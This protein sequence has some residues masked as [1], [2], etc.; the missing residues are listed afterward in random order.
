MNR[1]VHLT[2]NNSRGLPIP[3][4]S[5]Q[6]VLQI[7]SIG[8]LQ[9]APDL[10]VFPHSFSDLKD[11]IG[12]LSIV[13]LHEAQ[14]ADGKCVS[15]KAC[16]GNLMGFVGVNESSVSIHSR[17]THKMENGEVDPSSPDYF[18]YYMLQKV[19]SV[20]VFSLEH[21]SSRDDKILDFLFFLFPLMLKSAMSQGLYKEYRRFLHD[22][23]RV[24][25]TIDV[26]RFI[27]SDIPFRGNI[28]Y[29]TREYSYDNTIT[30]LVR[31]TIEYITHH[32]FGNSIL[33]N[34][35]ET[36]E[37]VRQ[38]KEATP[39]YCMRDRQRVLNENRRPKVHPYFTKYRELQQLCVHILRHESLKY[40]EEKD[41][42]HGVLFDGAWLW[43][44]Y[45]NTVLRGLGFHHPENKLHSGGF[46]MFKRQNE[47]EQISRNSR[48]LFPD[49]YKDDFILDAKYKHL[50][51]G[52]S[53]EDLYQVVTYMYC[54]KVNHG[55]YVYPDEGTNSYSKCQLEGY[56]GYIHLLPVSIPQ[57]KTNHDAFIQAMQL[58]EDSLRNLIQEVK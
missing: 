13:T 27:R 28:S 10:L 34:D 57:D 6:D 5:I 33:N 56:N 19:F 14:Y 21:A 32:P 23:D 51:R 30:Q 36:I 15:V 39:S 42:I 45:L 7:A 49:F 12:N 9:N 58:S 44:E 47:D 2:D 4:E 1:P 29:T 40:G 50:N 53:R 3:E 35:S 41:R 25:G 46:K 17:F 8:R 18:L 52:I 48:V 31:H 37:Y 43:E 55:G 11:G 22:D 26:N 54:K 20:N 16:T 24:K 38:I